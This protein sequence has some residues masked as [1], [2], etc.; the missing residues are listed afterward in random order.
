MTGVAPSGG[1]IDPIAAAITLTMLVLVAAT[2]AV[3]AGVRPF[4]RRRHGATGRRTDAATAG[5][6]GV[7]TV[8][9]LEGSL[10]NAVI[11]GE[12]SAAQYRRVMERLAAREDQRDR[13]SVP[14]DPEPPDR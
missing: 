2:I 13:L 4:R 1:A 5:G 9:S 8:T 3:A 14:T 12:I 11:S 7:A 10:V 6:A